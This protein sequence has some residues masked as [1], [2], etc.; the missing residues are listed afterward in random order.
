MPDHAFS[1]GVNLIDLIGSKAFFL[2][3]I[4]G[5][6]G[7]AAVVLKRTFAPDVH[8]HGTDA[9]IEAYHNGR[10]LVPRRLTWITILAASFTIGTGGSAGREGPAALIG[11]S[12]GSTFSRLFRLDDKTR[13]LVLLMG[14]SAGL[15]AVIGAPLGSA[16]FAVEFLYR[17]IH[18]ES[19]AL[20]YALVAAVAGYF[21]STSIHG[22][23]AAFSLPELSQGR[24]LKHFFWFVILGLTGGILASLIPTIFYKIKEGFDRMTV[25][26]WLKAG[27]GG[28]MVG[29]VGIFVP[30]ILGTGEHFLQQVMVEH[31]SI[32]LLLIV[33]FAKIFTFSVTLGSGG[34]GGVLF[35]SLF[36]G[37]ALGAVISAISGTL[38]APMVL[39]GMATIFA[40]AGRTPM[41]A[42]LMVPEITGDYS[43]L[44]P[45]ALA[46]SLSYLIQTLIADRQEYP[47]LHEAQP[48]NIW[49]SP[50]HHG[51]VLTEGIKLLQKG[52]IH[53]PP[54]IDL[55]DLEALL[56]IGYPVPLGAGGLIIFRGTL[57]S[58]AA[59]V[60]KTLLD[61]PF[62][63]GIWLL[64]IR[65]EE[66][67]LFPDGQ[68]CLEAGDNLIFLA[69][70]HN[71]P[72]LNRQLEF[73]SVFAN[74]LGRHEPEIHA[75]M[76]ADSEK[77]GS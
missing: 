44:P 42:L 8:S 21:V 15:S 55:P 3:L 16:F 50:T 37:A 60:N 64:E 25:P 48:A 31:L 20:I 58:E 47:T 69:P 75:K 36:I 10:G 61:S 1:P 76:M 30:T 67:A 40:A 27:I 38:Q 17:E 52:G 70:I 53:L 49:A 51:E 71:I 6:G 65:R 14:L 57:R 22:W 28:A 7:I 73:P 56:A 24:D 29:A 63:P 45:T 12:L 62:G 4:T 77:T 9:V 41:A 18:F 23:S 43:L 54:E 11:A 35:P 68:T 72:D 46:V 39:V 2:P 66:K 19:E 26:A 33:L 34:S 32:A 13:R 74:W 59:A 5:C